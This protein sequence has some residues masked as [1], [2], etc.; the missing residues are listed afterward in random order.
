[1]VGKVEKYYRE[2]LSSQGA[3]LCSLI[4]PD[5]SFM[6]KGV[7]IA[8]S[9]YEAGADVILIGGSIG[10][11]G[12]A[13][14][15][16][17]RRIKEEVPIPIVLFPGNISGLTAYADAVYFMHMLNSRDV[18]WLSTAQIQAAPVVAKLGIEPIA[19]TYLVVEPG[20]AVGWIGNANL[21]PRDRP[22]LG[23]ACALSARFSGS[24]VLIADSGSGAPS[25]APLPLI[26]GMAKACADE[27][28]LFSA[29]GVR[30]PAQ[31]AAQ[32]KAGACGI[33]VGTAFE[34]GDVSSKIK[35]MVRAVRAEG[36]KRV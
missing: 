14:D 26:Q 22:D 12:N 20:R 10:A 36:R 16:T 17:V 3:M 13:V 29:G 34:V 8:K 1:M 15:E 28:M 7:A 19:T 2:K 23:A 33:Q 32:I 9:S 25:P 21:L 6:E 18:Y 4:D 30:T 35:R 31:A 11:Q 24:H 27:V 5:K